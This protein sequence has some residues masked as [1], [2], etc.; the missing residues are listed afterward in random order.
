[1]VMSFKNMFRVQD[2]HS[3]LVTSPKMQKNHRKLEAVLTGG[4]VIREYVQSLEWTFKYG[5][6]AK[7]SHKIAEIKATD[8]KN[9][10][11]IFTW[12]IEGEDSYLPCLQRPLK[13][14]L[15]YLI[16]VSITFTC[17][18]VVKDSVRWPP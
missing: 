1:M 8:C 5:N 13:Q 2:G 16:P 7:N 14:V 11:I 15:Q 10:L 12:L 6:I 18:I 17:T 4:D 3:N 9:N